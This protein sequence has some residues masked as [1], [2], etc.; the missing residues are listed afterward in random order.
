[1]FASPLYI[2][3][4]GV[5]LMLLSVRV[6]RLRRRC[7]ISIGHGNVPCLERAMRVQANCV[8]YAPFALLLLFVMEQLTRDTLWVHLCGAA[9][10]LGR[11]LH[12]LG[13][14]RESEDFRLRV[15][16][17]VLTFSALSLAMLRILLAYT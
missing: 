15:T 1:M 8:E 13:V 11:T 9:L 5:L 10:L 4:A 2:V 7:K 12:A 16:G 14:S 3:A 6:I 17:M